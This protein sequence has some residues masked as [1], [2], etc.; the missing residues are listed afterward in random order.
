MVFYEVL[1]TDK[2]VL[3]FVLL[4]FN[5]KPKLVFFF[6]TEKMSPEQVVCN[7]SVVMKRWALYLELSV[8]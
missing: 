2:T 8:K 6:L 7:E 1:Q 5:L 4:Y 3:D